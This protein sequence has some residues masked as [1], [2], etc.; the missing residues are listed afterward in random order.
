MSRP[1]ER[2]R[3]DTVEADGPQRSG[4]PSVGTSKAAVPLAVCSSDG[5]DP[6]EHLA[7]ILTN[8]A[9]EGEEVDSA[10]PLYGN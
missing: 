9:I 4:R 8:R 7:S 6:E 2:G 10:V 5:V 1:I 3:L